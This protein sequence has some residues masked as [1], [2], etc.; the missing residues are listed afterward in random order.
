MRR[1]VG[2]LLLVVWFLKP[3]PAYGQAVS[4]FLLQAP[5]GFS[6]VLVDIRPEYDRRDVLVIYQIVL[7]PQ[8]TLPARLGLR[9]PAA[10]GEPHAVAMREGDELISL[11]Y[12][13]AAEGEWM[14]INFTTPAQ[15]IQVEY[16][17]PLLQRSQQKRSFEY[18]WPGDY[19]VQSLKV[20]VQQPV[21]ASNM[22][23]TPAFGSG[24]LLAD[25]MTYYTSTEAKAEAGKTV[26]VRFSYDKP[27]DTLSAPSQPVSPSQP[28][29]ANTP[30]RVPV[31][32][33]LTVSGAVILAAALGIGAWWI[34]HVRRQK[35]MLKALRR[36]RH[37]PAAETPS[38]TAQEAVFCHQCGFR[39]S[40][41]D[42]FCR[43]C[44]TKLRSG[45]G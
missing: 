26:T 4:N 44:G 34:W 40:P 11:P 13:T 27:D 42:L 14:R 25:G 23:F 21:N 28:L 6:S 38:V 33:L 39:A 7:S 8:A 24:Q 43:A 35:K 41:G 2:L 22:T 15:E 17:D 12:T 1:V 45:Q 36:R 30:G 19:A 20:M 9:I 18:R 3:L 32:T 31:S 37:T 29:G 16:Y 10:A 5:I